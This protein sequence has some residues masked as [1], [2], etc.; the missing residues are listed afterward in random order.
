MPATVEFFN[1]EFIYNV[2]V[3]V[4]DVMDETWK[5]L[6]CYNDSTISTVWYGHRC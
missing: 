3:T 6:E 5:F 4:L 2:D 1:M